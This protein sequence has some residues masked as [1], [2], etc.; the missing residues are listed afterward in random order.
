MRRGIGIDME[1]VHRFCRLKRGKHD[2]FLRRIY[3]ERELD[4]CYAVRNPGGRLASRFAAKEAVFK[5]L[6]HLGVHSPDRRSI[7]IRTGNRGVPTVDLTL[8]GR[9]RPLVLV[10][11]SCSG[12]QAMAFAIAES[13][14]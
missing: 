8:S 9:R 12:D 13:P 11:L 2:A 1:S 14:S 5:A 10:S 3:T 7:E 6:S 4:H